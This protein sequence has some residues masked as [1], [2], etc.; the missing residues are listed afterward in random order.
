LDSDHSVYVV[1]QQTLDEMESEAE[2][3]SDA[4]IAASAEIGGK[5]MFA[6]WDV[7][8]RSLRHETGH[9]L[10]LHHPDKYQGPYIGTDAQGNQTYTELDLQGQFHRKN[11][12]RTS[13]SLKGQV[14]NPAN[15]TKLENFQ[16][17]WI[18]QYSNTNLLNQGNNL[19]EKHNG[20]RVQLYINSAF[21]VHMNNQK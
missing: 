8:S 16:L 12:M 4:R 1:T 5:R 21:E 11:I 19:Y 10:G 20:T 18:E 17:L 9:W 6:T 3:S 14:N 2:T 13:A 7:D 15:A